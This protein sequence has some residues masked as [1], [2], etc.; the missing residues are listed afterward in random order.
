MVA[1]LCAE[2]LRSRRLGNPNPED[3]SSQ[4]KRPRVCGDNVAG[5]QCLRLDQVPDIGGSV[6]S[7]L[8]RM[9]VGSYPP[10]GQVHLGY[11]QQH[12]QRGRQRDRTRGEPQPNLN[13]DNGD[14]QRRQQ[15]QRQPRQKRH[16][17]HRH[18]RTAVL[19]GRPTDRL[20]LGFGPSK[21]AEGRQS[22]QHIAEV[23][24]KPVHRRP[25]P[26]LTLRGESPDE[27]HEHR[28]QRHGHRCDHC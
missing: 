25:G 27:D 23:V 5:R 1:R 24:T 3:D 7:V 18:R 8:G 14:R 22:G 6:T 12:R 16:P 10:Q 15:V 17:Q 2:P 9:E 11:Q 26:V 4:L 13:S 20:G 21:K 19:V 28:Y